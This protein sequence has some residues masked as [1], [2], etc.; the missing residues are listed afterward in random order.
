F[1]AAKRL[2]DEKKYAQA[3][4]LFHKLVKLDHDR[5]WW[6]FGLLAP[7]EELPKGKARGKKDKRF[8]GD[9]ISEASLF[10]EAECQ[11]LPKDYCTAV[12]PYTK[13]LNEFPNGQYTT[14]ACQGLFEIA[15]YWLGPTSRQ[16]DEYHEVLQ[17]KRSF[18][19]PA[20]YFH[21][22]KDMPVMD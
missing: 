6:E 8:G 7:Q 13:L 2:F 15:H 20:I 3:E 11:R 12:D 1:D 10:H 9:P 5:R 18:V 17:G 22:D 16:M 21:W 14:T 4:P 19:M